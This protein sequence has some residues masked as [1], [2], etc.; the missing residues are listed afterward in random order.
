VH[1]RVKWKRQDFAH[2]HSRHIVNQC[3]IIAVED[4]RV[5]RMMHNHCLAKSISDAAWSQF[6]ELLRIK[7]EWAGYTCIAVNPAYTSQ[8]CS[9][10][11]HRKTDLTLSDRIYHCGCC[12]L[13][14]DRDLNAALNILAVGLHCLGLAQEAP[15]L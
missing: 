5:N 4:I 11:G 7:A 15:G 9:R 12:G 8:N 6:L 2:Q 10:C 3:D 14:I 13:I 1:E